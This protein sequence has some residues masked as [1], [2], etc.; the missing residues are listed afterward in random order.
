VCS[1]RTAVSAER[2][3]RHGR[4]ED[5]AGGQATQDARLRIKGARLGIALRV[6]EH[7]RCA[8]HEDQL[9]LC[10]KRARRA[11]RPVRGSHPLALLGLHD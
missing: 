11:R 9:R 2:I 10:T 5:F 4:A 8:E 3:V 6:R 7:L 1:K